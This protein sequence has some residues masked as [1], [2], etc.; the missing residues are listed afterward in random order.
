MI[1]KSKC[2][3]CGETITVHPSGL[4]GYANVACSCGAWLEFYELGMSKPKA[5]WVTVDGVESEAKLWEAK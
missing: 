2:S 5:R 3:E 4:G 1:Y